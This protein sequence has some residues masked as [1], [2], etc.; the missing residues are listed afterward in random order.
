MNRFGPEAWIRVEILQPQSP[1]ALKARA[2]IQDLFRF[3]GRHPYHFR[4]AVGHPAKAFLAPLQRRLSALALD[5]DRRQ[6]CGL[7]DDS[8]MLFGRAAGFAPI[9][10]EGAQ[11][12]SIG[13]LYRGGPT[14]AQPV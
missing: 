10:R 6:M 9:D 14:R 8:L 13:G 7:F 12:A 4:D 3:Q 2:D 11:Y 1:D 5:R